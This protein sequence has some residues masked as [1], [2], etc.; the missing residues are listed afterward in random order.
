V[1]VL[2]IETAAFESAAREGASVLKPAY[3]SSF[4]KESIDRNIVKKGRD[5]KLIVGSVAGSDPTDSK[6]P[7][8]GG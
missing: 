3:F 1:P 6:Y 5:H 8:T 4:F 7:T 2:A